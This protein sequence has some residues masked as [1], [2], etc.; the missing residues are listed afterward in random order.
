MSELFDQV[1]TQIDRTNRV[2]VMLS[3]ALLDIHGESHASKNPLLCREPSCVRLREALRELVG[4]DVR[5][6]LAASLRLVRK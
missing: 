4:G 2:V 3:E 5:E 1:A 6:A